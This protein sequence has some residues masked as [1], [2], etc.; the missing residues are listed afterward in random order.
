MQAHFFNIKLI[1]NH[2]YIHLPI[3]FNFKYS[4]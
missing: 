4:N 3:M 1:I 2:N